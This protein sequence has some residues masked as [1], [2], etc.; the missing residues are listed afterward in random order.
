MEADIAHDCVD[1]VSAATGG[2]Q[3]L[4]VQICDWRHSK[5]RGITSFRTLRRV[6]RI[7]VRQAHATW[8]GKGARRRERARPETWHLD[9]N[10]ERNDV[11]IQ[12]FN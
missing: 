6:T 12:I 2:I 9:R 8:M 10:E 3:L 5:C 4:D 11:C 7:P 1:D